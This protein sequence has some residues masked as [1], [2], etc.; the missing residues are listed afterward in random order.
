MEKMPIPLRGTLVFLVGMTALAT[1]LNAG[2]SS[3]PLPQ[4]P[5]R[6]A[7]IYC[8]GNTITRT[9]VLRQFLGFDTGS[10]FDSVR[11]RTV[12]KRLEATRLF[13]KVA[14]IHLVKDR[15]VDL[16]V[17]V[18]EAFYWG[19]SDLDFT[20]YTSRYGKHGWWLC[21]TL[22]VQNTNVG[23]RMET[24]RVMVRFWEWRAAALWWT[25]PLIPSRWFVG[26][27]GF[28]DQRPD[29]ALHI[30]RTEIAGSLTAGRFLFES[31]KAY[32]SLIPDYQRRIARNGPSADTTR[33][34][35]AFG[36]LGWSTD[37]RSSGY[38]PSS[39]W[40]LTLETRSNVLYHQASA[41][42]YAQISPDI[43]WYLP[44][45]FSR[46]KTACRFT[47]TSRTND[48]GIQNR[49][50]LGGIGIV[51]GYGNYGI[52]L[53]KSASGACSFSAEYRFPIYQLSSVPQVLPQGVSKKIGSMFFDPRSLSPRIDGAIIVDYGRVGR[54]ISDCFSRGGPDYIS[55]TDIGFGLRLMEPTLRWSGCFDVV[56]IEDPHTRATRFL[57]YPSWGAY[58]DLPF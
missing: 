3:A 10:V 1:A 52:D 39:G 25:K 18:K 54:T 53:R 9:S 26:A 35:Q 22:G 14:I 43:K 11:I 2:D 7:H 13:T 47:L 20:P 36:V 57:P 58:L 33:Y 41:P 45:L 15:G 5:L 37:R 50:I 34:Y 32:C 56:W 6:I 16:Y 44:G 49:L 30:D 27:S 8:N 19:I 46:H 12:K 48:A 21:P 23:G 29:N 24:I 4:V 38:D 31:S 42:V 28:F 17:I 55:G 51:R 40:A